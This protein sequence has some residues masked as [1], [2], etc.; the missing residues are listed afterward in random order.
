MARFI[1]VAR[2]MFRYIVAV[3]LFL[4]LIPLLWS[5]FPTRLQPRQPHEPTSQTFAIGFDLAA[6]YGCAYLL[7]H[8]TLTN[9]KLGL[10]LSRTGTVL[11]G[12]LPKLTAMRRTWK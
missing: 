6:S 12:R 3:L 10:S 11:C 5:F 9:R 2:N 7:P 1:E 4:L 8:W